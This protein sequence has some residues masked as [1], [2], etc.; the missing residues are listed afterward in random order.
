MS[1]D[2]A[3][4][5]ALT[6][7]AL[8]AGA[9]ILAVYGCD[10]AVI[11][12]ADRSPVTDADVAAEAIIVAALG[13]CLTGVPVVAEEACAAG[14]APGSLGRRFVLVDPLDGTREF[15][16]RNGEFTVNIALVEDGRP[17]VGVVLAPV[18]GLI[19]V[20]EVGVGARRGRVEADGGVAWTPIAVTA[21]PVEGFRVMAS[22]S[23]AGAETEALLARLPV[24]ARVAVGSSLKFC[25][26]AE[27]AADFY[28]RLGRTMEWDTA[29]GEAV[30]R[31]AGG[32]VVR[33]DGTPL[34]YGKTADAPDGAFAN[35]A[36]LAFGDP[37]CERAVLARLGGRAPAK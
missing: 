9:A 17:V 15:V 26:L 11:A 24:V 20:G 22:R 3:L 32:T 5:T 21:A 37:A 13:R 27:G 36:F 4:V 14:H 10:F 7:A 16:S 6:D 1:T 30:L 2:S 31:A 19:W 23:H 34:V 28:P 29:A 25:R 8:E 33:F 12:K 35:P 18:L